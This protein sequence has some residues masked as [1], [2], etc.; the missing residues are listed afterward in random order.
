MLARYREPS[1]GLYHH[2]CLGA[3]FWLSPV[4]CAY[5]FHALLRYV[6]PFASIAAGDLLLQNKQHA[7]LL[8]PYD[9][10]AAAAVQFINAVRPGLNVQT[11]ALRD[12]QVTAS[13][14]FVSPERSAPHE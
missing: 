12:P 5:A 8:Q 2:V 4:I 1:C 13:H 9:D 11:A 3:Y 10:R 14:T 6:E 7:E